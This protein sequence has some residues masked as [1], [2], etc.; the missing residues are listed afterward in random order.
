MSRQHDSMK[1]LSLI[2]TVEASGPIDTA[3]RIASVLTNIL[4]F[5]LSI[6]GVLGI[7]GLV[8]AGVLYLS[9]A[10]DA[11]RVAW[12]KKAMLGSVV[13]LVIALGGLVLIR[14]LADIVQ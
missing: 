4:E 2:A 7:L 10:G 6:V 9:A 5:L 8:I 3:P 13:G 14:T 11:R 12:A 1:L